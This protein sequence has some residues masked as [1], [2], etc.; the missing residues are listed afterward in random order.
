M[1]RKDSTVSANTVWGENTKCNWE[2]DFLPWQYFQILAAE[3][4][5]D[6][7]SYSLKDQIVY[8]WCILIAL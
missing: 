3:Y 8:N 1:Q 2:Y 7:F 4:V 6:L 5:T